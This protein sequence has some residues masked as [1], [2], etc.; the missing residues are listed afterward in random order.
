VA[1]GALGARHSHD[2]LLNSIVSVART[3]FNARAASIMLHDASSGELVF[4]A[5]AGEGSAH[6][7]GTRIPAATGIAGWV[8]S[9]R[10]P[11]VLEDVAAD[12]RF[13]RDVAEST[14]YVPKGLMA[15]P[16]LLEDR[17]LG[18]LSVL[19]RPA[20]PTFTLPEMELLGHFSHQA[21]LALEMT[22]RASAAGAILAD[23]ESPLSDLAALADAIDRLDDHRRKPAHALIA[24]LR[25]LLS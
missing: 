7:V 4:A 19:D 5:V 12:P 1:A 16:L 14:G 22:E 8:L 25:D 23:H 17:A 13:A 2:A 21:A 11:I 3:I 15:T 20:R 9:A 10:Q 6:L 24:A 18:V